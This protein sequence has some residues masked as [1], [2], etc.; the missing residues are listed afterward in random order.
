MPDTTQIDKGQVASRR[1]PNIVLWLVVLEVG[2]HLVT[3]NRYG[4]F[5]DELYYLACSRHLAWGYVDHPPLIALLTWMVAHSLGTTLFALRLLPALAGGAL[6]WLTA[7][8]AREL[9]GGRFAQILSA[10]AVIP[11]PI[12]LILN[13]W[14][15]MNAFEPLLWTS[16]LWCAVRMINTNDPRY[17]LW[18]GLL[19]GIGLENKYSML[20]CIGGLLLGMALSGERRLLLSGWFLV[21]AAC[22]FLFFLPNLVWSVHNHFPFLEFE[23]NSRESGSRIIRGPLAFVWDQALIMNPL[24]GPLWV[25]GLGWLLVSRHGRRH[26][27]LGWTCVS[28]LVLLMLLKSKNYYVAPIYPILFAAGAIAIET[29]TVERRWVRNGYVGAIVLSGLVLA[30]LVMPLLSP[31]SFVKYHEA[32]GGFTPVHFENLASTPL[33]QYFSD[34]FGWEDMARNTAKA[35]TDL[36]ETERAST[37]IFANDYGEAAAIDF[38]GPRFGLPASISKNESFWLWGPRNY[39]GKSVIVLGSDGVGDREHFRTVQAVGSVANPYARTNEQ[40]T[41]FICHD[42]SPSLQEL[43]PKIKSW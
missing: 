3:A 1:L 26:K 20:I 28:I 24:L 12:Y 5:R 36:P 35:Y 14:L 4:I 41:I 33:P 6:V 43:W 31:Q 7:S 27:A 8:I 29:T 15:T 40:F 25:A 9:G 34:E 23:R 39:T 10:L 16:M 2:I 38:F 42:L 17:W 30:P 32:L 18:I 21:G 11:V 13:H 22:A 19:A 37:A